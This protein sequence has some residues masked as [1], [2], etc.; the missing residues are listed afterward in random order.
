MGGDNR[1]EITR[2]VVGADTTIK[3]VAYPLR[4]VPNV[5]ELRAELKIG[6]VCVVEKEVF[7]KRNVPVVPPRAAHRVGWFVAPG[8]R[9][10]H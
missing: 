1:T 4:M 2:T 10:W 5:E 6:A 3:G 7:E 8:S 9:C